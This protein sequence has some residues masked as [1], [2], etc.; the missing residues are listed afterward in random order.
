ML[1]FLVGLHRA[2]SIHS[3]TP[4]NPNK[5]IKTLPLYL[6]CDTKTSTY[7]HVDFFLKAAAVAAGGMAC[8]TRRIQYWDWAAAA[9]HSRTEGEGST[10]G[11]W[12]WSVVPQTCYTPD[13]SPQMW[14]T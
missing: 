7:L 6:P 9:H 11:C 10:E 12:A 4:N 3:S 8:E 14:H 5:G 2:Y 13:T 1:T